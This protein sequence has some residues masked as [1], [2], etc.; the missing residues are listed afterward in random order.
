MQELYEARRQGKDEN[1]PAKQT[2]YLT[3]QG[4]AVRIMH[5]IA[6]PDSSS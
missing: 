1:K 6:R 3:A 2:F 5:G 4:N